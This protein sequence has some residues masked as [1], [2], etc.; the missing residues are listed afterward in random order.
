MAAW[1]ETKPAGSRNPKLG[2]DDIREFKQCVRERLAI[3]HQFA[4]SES[5]AFGAAG[6]LIGKHKQV[7][8]TQ[9]GSDPTTTTNEGAVYAKQ[10]ASG[11]TD[12][13]MRGESNETV[14]RLTRAN[15]A[16]FNTL[17]FNNGTQDIAFPTNQPA[18]A[19]FML[20]DANTI[21]WFYVNTAPPFW[22]VVAAGDYGLRVGATGGVTDGAWAIS[23]MTVGGI[24]ANHT[25]DR[26]NHTHTLSVTTAAVK[27]AEPEQAT[28]TVVTGVS[29]GSS[30]SG[31]TGNVSADHVHA[32][33]GDGT[34]RYAAYIGKLCALDAA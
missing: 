21:A 27:A 6:S 28:T 14:A 25:H 3:D 26:Q 30:G 17:P 31:S 9:L 4:A 24:S 22:K 8:L 23:G 2:D 19:K 10:G 12:L 20:G 18:A 15:M 34:W 32:V 5:P 33:S 1:D 13:F 7:T 11:Q 29:V 16:K